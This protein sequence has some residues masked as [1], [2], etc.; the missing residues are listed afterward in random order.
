MSQLYA[1]SQSNIPASTPDNA[2]APPPKR[3]HRSSD[4]QGRPKHPVSAGEHDSAIREMDAA[5]HPVE[6]I[7]RTF[8]CSVAIAQRRLAML[9]REVQS[10]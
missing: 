9:Q 4:R 3:A 7:A 1:W 10:A 2:Y 5:G 8:G 6:N